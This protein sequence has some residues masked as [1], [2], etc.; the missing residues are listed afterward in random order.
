MH[1]ISGAALPGSEMT[2]PQRI[3][4]VL[5]PALVLERLILKRWSGIQRA[6]GQAWLRSL[7]VQGFLTEG[8]WLRNEVGA[9]A[10]LSALPTTAFA[11]WLGR[12]KRAP[13]RAPEPVPARPPQTDSG[14]E[15]GIKPFAHLRKVIG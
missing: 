7:L 13:K 8:Q 10:M 2:E 15:Q 6:R 12:P 9:A 3:S 5:D 11:R 14:A 1:S 4:V